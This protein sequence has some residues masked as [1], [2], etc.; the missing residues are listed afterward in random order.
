M[1][2]IYGK[3]RIISGEKYRPTIFKRCD[4]NFLKYMTIAGDGNP[5][6][7]YDR[8]H[9]R[10]EVFL[11]HTMGGGGGGGG[12]APPEEWHNFKLSNECKE[13]R[14]TEGSQDVYDKLEQNFMDRFISKSARSNIIA[15]RG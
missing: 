5:R 15:V 4:D 10:L 12:R 9:D 11:L 13:I 1:P 2:F 7:H 3:V 6:Y 8:R 14:F